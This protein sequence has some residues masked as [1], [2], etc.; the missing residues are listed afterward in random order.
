MLRNTVITYAVGSFKDCAMHNIGS[1]SASSRSLLMRSLF[2]YIDTGSILQ[3]IEDTVHVQGT[4]AAV[5]YQH[6][7]TCKRFICTCQK[8]QMH[9]M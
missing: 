2:S 4:P 9:A 6:P 7:E 1:P 5:A 3:A 8:A